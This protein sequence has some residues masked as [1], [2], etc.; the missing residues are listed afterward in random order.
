MIIWQYGL[1]N[2]DINPKHQWKILCFYETEIG[3]HVS[4]YDTENGNFDGTY[5]EAA[6]AFV[7]ASG[8]LV[9]FDYIP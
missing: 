7:M 8:G 6:Q 1:E 4:E 2:R 9:E 5:T 3:D